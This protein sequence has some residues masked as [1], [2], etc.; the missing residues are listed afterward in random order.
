MT[1]RVSQAI[2]LLVA[3]NAQ[4]E[5]FTEKRPDMAKLCAILL[6]CLYHMTYYLLCL[7]ASSLDYKCYEGRS[8]FYLL[9]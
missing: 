3:L 4:K 5:K 6:Y 7:I 8:M 2:T 9:I 1:L